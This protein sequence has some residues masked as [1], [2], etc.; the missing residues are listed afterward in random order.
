MIANVI[1]T[2]S[3]GSRSRPLHVTKEMLG[4]RTRKRILY[5]DQN[6]FSSVYRGVDRQ[7]DEAMQRIADLRDLQLLA[8][9]YSPTHESEADLYKHRD[10]LLRFVQTIARGHY[11]WP[12][13]QETQIVKAFQAYLANAPSSYIKGGSRR[14]SDGRSRLGRPLFC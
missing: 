9:P 3:S 7:W 5:P 11:F 12:S 13:Y 10:D 8:V 2:V 1:G 6:L 4:V 14:A